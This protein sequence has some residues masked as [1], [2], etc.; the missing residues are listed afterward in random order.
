[1]K[2]Y[3][4]QF[5]GKQFLSDHLISQ[6]YC[7]RSCE[8]KRYRVSHGLHKLKDGRFC[9]QCGKHFFP[10]GTGGNNK[11][12]CSV[13]CSVKSAKESRTKFWKKQKDPNALKKSYYDKNREKVGP[14]GNLKRF[15]KRHPNAPRSCQSCGENRVLDIAH[16]PGHKRNGAWRSKENTS[17]E[18]V[19][20][21]CPTCHALLDRMNYSPSELG[22]S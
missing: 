7:S 20:I 6:A 5:C 19:W 17:L 3:Y 22:L 15:Y 11:Q 18:K 14:D 16:K 1:M 10:I 13:E 21:L 12:H 4:C 2:E 9:K 8:G